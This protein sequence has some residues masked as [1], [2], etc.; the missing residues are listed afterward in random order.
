[1]AG[2]LCSPGCLCTVPAAVPEL[3]TVLGAGRWTISLRVNKHFPPSHL[4]SKGTGAEL[5]QVQGSSEPL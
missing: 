4:A 5:G 1:M 2:K 3:G